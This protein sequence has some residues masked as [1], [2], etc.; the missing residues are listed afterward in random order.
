MRCC[1]ASGLSN[2]RCRSCDTSTRDGAGEC[3]FHS[4][5]GP[6]LSRSEVVLLSPGHLVHQVGQKSEQKHRWGDIAP[7]AGLFV[8]RAD[9]PAGRAPLEFP[10]FPGQGAA[11]AC[12]APAGRDP[13]PGSPQH[14]PTT[15]GP[16]APAWAPRPQDA[17]SASIALGG[18]R[19]RGG[20]GSSVG[21]SRWGLPVLENLRTIHKRVLQTAVSMC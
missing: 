7:G 19:L 1:I 10:A 17:A 4:A 21:A 18:T 3:T 16:P 14:P 6:P 12:S 13:A 20:T 15:P 5:G 11:R 9:G 8:L 2:S